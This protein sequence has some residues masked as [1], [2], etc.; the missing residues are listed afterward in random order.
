MLSYRHAFHAGNFAD[1]LKHLVLTGTL[2]YATTKAAPLLYLDTHAGAG[3]YRL[4]ASEAQRTGEAARG[5]LQ[6]DLAALADACNVAGAALLRA[7][8][9]LV[10]PFLARGSYP[11]SPLVAAALLRPQDHLHLCELHPADY[12]RLCEITQRDRRIRV[13]QADGFQRAVALLPPAQ[14]RAVVLVDPS[15]EVKQDYRT[16]VRT[17]TAIHQRMPAAQVLLWYPVV[18]RSDIARLCAAL[19]HSPL[20]DVWQVELGLRPDAPGHGMSASGLLLLN[21]PWTLPTALREALPLVQASLGPAA[22]YGYWR[23]ERLIEE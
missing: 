19:Q 17:L 4:D 10:A 6:L 15:Y 16:V 8:H 3:H 21:P 5:I 2:R 23:V 22:A 1:V 11:G 7:Y 9:E 13:E 12:A 18:E 14:K 20:R